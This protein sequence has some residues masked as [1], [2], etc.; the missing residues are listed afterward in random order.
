MNAECRMQNAECRMQNA[1]SELAPM[2]DLEPLLDLGLDLDQYQGLWAV[3]EDQFTLLFDQASRTDLVAHVLANR[4]N[5]AM[6]A[7]RVS[8]QEAAETSIAVIEIRGTLTKRGS[9]LSMA[10]S[11]VRIRRAVRE[12]A[13]DRDVDAILLRIDS[14]GGTV[15]GTSELAREIAA[16]DQRKPVF[17]F[18]EDLAASA[19][20]WVASQ[21]RQIFANERTAIVG[22]IGSYTVL[23]DFSG[24][25]AQQRVRPVVIR[26]GEFKGLGTWGTEITAAHKAYIQER[27]DKI[28]AEFTAGVAAGRKM[29]V[30][31]VE[32]L[33]DGRV[34]VAEDA[35]VLGLIDGIQTFEQTMGQLAELA[36]KTSKNNRRKSTMSSQTSDQTS[37]GG[38]DTLKLIETQGLLKI[39]STAATFD[40]LL[41]ALPKADSEF[42][43]EAQKNKLTVEQACNAWTERLQEQIAAKD[44]QIAEALEEKAKAAAAQKRS[45][46]EPLG[47]D[48]G[49]SA[50]A[51]SE[52]DDPVATFDQKVRERMKAGISRRKAALAVA[53]AE[54]VLHE[55]F[56][57]GTNKQNSKLQSL[58]GERFELV[59]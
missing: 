9:S 15:A 11:M 48:A 40:E 46:V 54:P 33:A 41:A 51:T 16:A 25:A 47:G 42:L 5:T 44:K 23:Y 50:E 3:D 13:N 26:S 27:V 49:G 18:V 12:A 17:A 43:V 1:E 52:Y 31:K 7:A 6:A 20:Y 56:L 39:G 55:A 30:A 21:A 37:D 10:G 2:I 8:R 29:S 59:N 36:G 38:G 24:A 35:R 58:I 45:G 19:A 34:H 22:S 4:G 14:P 28:Q 57:R 32:E 53:R